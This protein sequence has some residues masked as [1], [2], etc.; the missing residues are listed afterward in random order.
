MRI[1]RT[2]IK[3][4]HKLLLV[5]FILTTTA[6]FSQQPD[7]INKVDEKGLKQ[8]VWK[9]YH[10]NGIVRY[11]GQFKNDKPTGTFKHYDDK[12]KLSMKVHHFPN[13]S[14][15][16]MYYQTGELK[17]TGK[18]VNQQK[19]STWMYY[20]DN[21]HPLA[22]EFYF[23]GKRE[24]TWK[25]FYSNGKIAEEKNY[26]DN[27]EHGDWIEYYE[28]GKIKSKSTY[29]KGRMEGKRYFYYE[30]GLTKIL[31]NYSRD[32]RHGVWM[33]YNEDGTTKKKEEYNFGKRI[34]ENKD[35]FM[36]I[37]DTLNRE[38]KDILDFED[39]FPQKQLNKNE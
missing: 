10:P 33:Y 16:N 20:H 18:Y 39:L 2:T 7:T 24:G 29:D 32:V 21:G 11:E 17:A 19:D 5:F 26:T 3:L 14:Y 30:N 22:E 15:A 1:E 37:D 38:K 34:D 4:L 35:D 27:I 9:K 36:I 23:N 28:S 13:T 8:G 31:G 6:S 12:G 25:I